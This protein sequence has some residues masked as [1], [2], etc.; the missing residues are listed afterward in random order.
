[1]PGIALTEAAMAND[2]YGQPIII[3]LC[4]NVEQTAVWHNVR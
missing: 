4:Q 1:M 2:G 3:R